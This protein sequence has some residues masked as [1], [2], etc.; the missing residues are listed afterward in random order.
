[1]SYQELREI[2]DGMYEW[3]DSIPPSVLENHAPKGNLGISDED[4]LS[5][6]LVA[7]SLIKFGYLDGNEN[8]TEKGAKLEAFMDAVKYF[9]AGTGRFQNPF[10][11]YKKEARKISDGEL[12]KIVKSPSFIELYSEKLKKNLEGVKMI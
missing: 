5:I 9:Y 4:I 8:A 6:K 11:E 3:F 1:M 12:R 10:E 7:E 2:K